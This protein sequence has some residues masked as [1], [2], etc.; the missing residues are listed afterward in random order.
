MGGVI[1][2]QTKHNYFIK[3]SSSKFEFFREKLN[4]WPLFDLQW[5]LNFR[6]FYHHLPEWRENWT[7]H[8]GAS[9]SPFRLVK[10]KIQ[11]FWFSIFYYFWHFLGSLGGPGT[12]FCTLILKIGL[13][14]LSDEPS[15][16]FN[17]STKMHSFEKKWL[18]KRNTSLQKNWEVYKPKL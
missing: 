5:P 4:F 15:E 1:K 14:F 17:K 6:I 8:F 16:M 11:A 9:S 13:N 12:L 10:L 7:W 18:E 2:T 3:I